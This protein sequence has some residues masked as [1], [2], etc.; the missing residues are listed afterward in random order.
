MITEFAEVLHEFLDPE[1]NR[2]RIP[3]EH[4]IDPIS[5]LSRNKDQEELTT[6]ISDYFKMHFKPNFNHLASL[7]LQ[8]N[9][10]I[11]PLSAGKENMEDAL[12]ALL[13]L[14]AYTSN[15]MGDSRMRSLRQSLNTIE[16]HL[17]YVIM[18]LPD[19]EEEGHDVPDSAGF[20]EHPMV[21]NTK[22]ALEVRRDFWLKEARRK[23]KSYNLDIKKADILQ[24]TLEEYVSPEALGWGILPHDATDGYLVELFHMS[25]EE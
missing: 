24:Q 3:G 17:H 1:D 5:G 8:D 16:M 25:E 20:R 10:G 12:T 2:G 19:Q 13:H 22:R 6:K 9:H 14:K 23:K 21:P 7:P 18:I 11:D 4:E 15:M